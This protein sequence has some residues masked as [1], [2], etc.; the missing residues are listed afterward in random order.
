MGASEAAAVLGILEAKYNS[1]ALWPKPPKTDDPEVQDVFTELWMFDLAMAGM[2]SKVIEKGKPP[3]SRYQAPIKFRKRIDD[4]RRRKPEW[5]GFLDE[6][7]KVCDLVEER[8]EL[9]ER[10]RWARRR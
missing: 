8:I 2:V 4:L 6:L 10:L 5:S 1:H 3:L 7:S 9:V